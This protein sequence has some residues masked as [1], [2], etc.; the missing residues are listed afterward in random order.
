MPRP[1]VRENIVEAALVEFHRRGFNACSVEDITKA[2][3]VPKGSFY[4]HFKSKQA[5]GAEVVDRYTK[6]SGWETERRDGESALEQL[7]A[8]FTAM[9]NVLADDDFALGC[10][11]GNMGAEVADHSPVIREQV[12]SSLKDWSASIAQSIRDARAEDDIDAGLDADALSRFI[13]NAWEGS[14]IRAKVVKNPEPIDDF[15]GAVF[16]NLLARR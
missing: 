13:L 12:G 10:L 16:D 7:R 4:N 3:G 14:L 15:F 2:A 11:I 8:R 5:L 9:R 6:G 1:N